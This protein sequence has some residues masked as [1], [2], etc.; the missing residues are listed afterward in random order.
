MG[1]KQLI[2]WLASGSKGIE[3]DLSSETPTLT[4]DGTVMKQPNAVARAL[5]RAVN[6]DLFGGGPAHEAQ[7][8]QWQTWASSKDAFAEAVALNDILAGRS[9]LV[10]SGVTLADIQ[11]Y[12]AL[13]P[14]VQ[15]SFPGP[16]GGLTNLSR[17]FNQIQHSVRLL[18]PEHDAA[19]LPSLVPFASLY[20]PLSMPVFN[21]QKKGQ[22]QGAAKP[23]SPQPPAPPGGKDQP[24]S[25]EDKKDKGAAKDKGQ[26]KEPKAAPAGGGGKGGEGKKEDKKEKKEGKEPKAQA[27]GG[28]GKPAE[29]AAGGDDEN[30]NHLDIRVGRIVKAWKHPEAEKLWCEEID[31]GEGEPRQIASGLRRFYAE[32]SDLTGRLVL[33]LANLKPRALVGFKSHGMVLCASND[34][35]VKFV[36]VPPSAQVGDRVTFPAF[37]VTEALTPAQVAKKKVFEKLAPGLATDGQGVANFKGCPFTLPSGGTCTAPLTNAHVS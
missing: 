5:A 3:V 8:V 1:V 33:V 2:Q 10:G 16:L 15:L 27:A 19:L 30:P 29:G 6:P 11:V 7:V 17:W 37:P 22:G 9:Y 25:K 14:A 36:D 31:C 21:K 20:K 4:V 35:E 13:A 32:E 24:A 34:A 26:A 23:G 28:G 18:F 12:W